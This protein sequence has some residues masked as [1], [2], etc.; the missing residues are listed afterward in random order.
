MCN[1]GR[2]LVQIQEILQKLQ[3][4]S[5][6]E[7]VAKVDQYYVQFS[8]TLFLVPHFSGNNNQPPLI[9]SRFSL[10]KN[11]YTEHVDTCIRKTITLV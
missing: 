3:L 4:L 11:T 7:S 10:Q 5:V 9:P 1:D 6:C 8:L 2:G